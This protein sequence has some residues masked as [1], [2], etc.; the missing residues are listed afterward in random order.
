MSHI[1]NKKQALDKVR[2]NKVPFLPV[3]MI[4]SSLTES[5]Y[6]HQSLCRLDNHVSTV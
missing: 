6:V 5:H 3:K 1:Q 2:I 4:L